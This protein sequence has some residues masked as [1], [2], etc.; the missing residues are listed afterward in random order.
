[1]VRKIQ[2]YRFMLYTKRLNV[3]KFTLF[4]TFK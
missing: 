2:K 3:T 4:L 1:M